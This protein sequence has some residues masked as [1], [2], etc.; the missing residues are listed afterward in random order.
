MVKKNTLFIAKSD[1]PVILFEVVLVFCIETGF[2]FRTRM[3]PEINNK[4]LF[5]S[6]RCVPCG[7]FLHGTINFEYMIFVK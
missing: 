2:P 3:E 1:R 5:G 7:G 4:L 6:S